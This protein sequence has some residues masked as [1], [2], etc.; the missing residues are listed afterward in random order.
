[1][2]NMKKFLSLC[3][4]I[5]LIIVSSSFYSIRVE[6][7]FTTG[8]SF[9]TG[10]FGTGSSFNIDS[11]VTSSSTSVIGFD[12]KE[13]QQSL[14][15]KGL[16]NGKI[17]GILGK[18]TTFA[19]KDLQKQKGLDVTGTV[20]SS[21]L[22]NLNLTPKLKTNSSSGSSSV[23]DS[24]TNVTATAGDA[25]A[26]VFFTPPSYDGGSP[27]K[28][29]TV[30]SFPVGGVDNNAGST[31]PIHTVSGLKNGTPY[32]F[33]VVASNDNWGST[34]ANIN[35]VNVADAAISI[36]FIAIIIFQKKFFAE[37]NKK[38]TENIESAE[39]SVS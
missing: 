31:L 4:F 22:A 1:M 5:L 2:S 34:A 29:Y 14:K 10:S 18:K 3:G 23:P 15:D 28:G 13:L 16:Y 21:T 30:F 38:E 17:D 7:S 32:T 12:V 36:G 11:S 6:A 20:D 25:K 27:I 26:T 24:P 39:E 19:V 8:S 35:A 33:I 37:E 9:G